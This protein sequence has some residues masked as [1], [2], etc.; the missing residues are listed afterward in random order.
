MNIGTKTLEGVL[1]LIYPK[2]CL[3]CEEKTPT[4]DNIICASCEFR[5]SKTDYHLSKE[6]EFTLRFWGRVNIENGTALYHFV[7]GGKV[8]QLIHHLKYRGKS[9]VGIKL[10]DYYGKILKAI[11]DYQKIDAIVPVPLHPKKLHQR[12][13]N[14]SDLIAKGLSNAMG[15]PW[16]KDGLKRISMTDTQTEKTRLERFENVSKVF[17]LDNS[18]AVAGKHVLL[19]D[20]VMTT[21][22]TLEA[23]TNKL[24]SLNNTKVSLLTL[25]IASE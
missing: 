6:N 13:Y 22:A 7:K 2:L 17:V 23:C 25:A 16:I 5:L 9:Q 8:Q 3:A 14:Q 24:L 1:A 20:D 21:G 4:K 15:I 11:P 19:V 10:G 18:T 12:G